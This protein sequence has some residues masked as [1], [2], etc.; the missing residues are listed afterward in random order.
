M[1]AEHLKGP[2]DLSKMFKNDRIDQVDR[3]DWIKRR[4]WNE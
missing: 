2:K 4:D 1:L 3:L